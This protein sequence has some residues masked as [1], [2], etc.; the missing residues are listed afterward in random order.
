MVLDLLKSKDIVAIPYKG[1]VLTIQTY[2]NL[3]FREF[4]DLDIFIQ[5]NNIL[6][7]KTLL[8]QHGYLPQLKLNKDQDDLHLKFQREYKLINPKNEVSVE[9]QWSFSGMCCSFQIDPSFLF[10]KKRSC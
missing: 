5:K 2:G 3:A 8:I 1:P 6:I 9:I 7:A 4:D 10:K